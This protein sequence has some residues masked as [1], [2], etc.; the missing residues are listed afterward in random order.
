M[1]LK[2]VEEREKGEGWEGLVSNVGRRGLS[3][4]ARGEEREVEVVSWLNAELMGR[5]GWADG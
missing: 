2:L 3:R 1:C 5:D 4:R